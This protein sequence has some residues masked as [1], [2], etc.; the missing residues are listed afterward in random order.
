VRFCGRPYARRKHPGINADAAAGGNAAR[1][2]VG[3]TP[4]IRPN[5]VVNE[6]MLRNPTERQMSATERSVLR[7]SAA[8]RSSRRVSRY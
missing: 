8:A 1:Y 4:N 3:E 7:S 5:D 2:S 6:P